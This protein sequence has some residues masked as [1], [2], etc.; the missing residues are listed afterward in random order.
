MVSLRSLLRILRPDLTKGISGI[1]SIIP[2]EIKGDEFYAAIL[3]LAS[4]VEARHI[5][6]IGSSSGQGSTDAFVRGIARNPARPQLHCM[7]ISKT[8]FAALRDH[9]AGNPQVKVYN[10]SSVPAAEL[11][12]ADQVAQFYRDQTTKLND[13]PLEQVLGWLEADRAY[14]SDAVIPDGIRHILTQIGVASF[15]LVLIDGSEFTGEPELER[16]YGAAWI[17]LDDV[18]AH[19]NFRNYHRLRQDPAYRLVREDWQVRNGF[20]IFQRV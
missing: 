19:K 4:T 12:S 1:E 8:R 7:E 5:L 10:A 11:P 18:N 9:H 14:M 3:E 17:L 13:Y 15:D 6:E 16:V 2:P 20:A